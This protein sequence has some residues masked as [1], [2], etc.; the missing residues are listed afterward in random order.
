V[1]KV[2]VSAS[3]SIDGFGAG[4]QQ[5]LENPTGVGGEALSQRVFATRAFKRMHDTDGAGSD[6]PARVSGASLRSR[7]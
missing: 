4:P 1:S 7:P 5:S 3:I 6:T 2:R